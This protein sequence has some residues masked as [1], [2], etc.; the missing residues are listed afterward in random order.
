VAILASLFWNLAWTR[1]RDG[2][3]PA[4]APGLQAPPV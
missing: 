2:A 3:E 4:A 1:R